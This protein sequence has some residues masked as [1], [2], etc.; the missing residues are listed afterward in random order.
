[1]FF[2]FLLQDVRTKNIGDMFH[3]IQLL[4]DPSSKII[5]SARAPLLGI[6][7]KPKTVLDPGAIFFEEVEFN[8][9]R[10]KL[11][12]GYLCKHSKKDNMSLVICPK[13]D[14][15]YTEW[16]TVKLDDYFQIR[17]RH[18]GLCLKKGN[19]GYGISFNKLSIS[20][21]N[22]LTTGDF[23]WTISEIEELNEKPKPEEPQQQNIPDS[24]ESPLEDE[25][26][27]GFYRSVFQ[28]TMPQYSMSRFSRSFSY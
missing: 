10:F 17:T 20:V 18:R 3:S 11:L 12:T 7:E 27:S 16:S 1:M 6:A 28:R 26:T 15:S 19:P 24:N 25:S 14:D 23:Q 4:K 21:S 9:F 13:K 2:F 8:V 5:E 22:C